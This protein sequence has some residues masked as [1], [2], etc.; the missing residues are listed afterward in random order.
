MN[1]HIYTQKNYNFRKFLKIFW[2][3]NLEDRFKTR[4]WDL[5]DSGC[6]VQEY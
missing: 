4:T 3:Q 6:N 5:L 1:S 2:G